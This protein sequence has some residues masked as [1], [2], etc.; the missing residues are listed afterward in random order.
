[1]YDLVDRPV[2]DLDEGSRFLVFAMRSWVRS[3]TERHCPPALLGP[4]FAKWQMTAALPHFHLAMALLNRD[5]LLTFHFGALCCGRVT[6]DEAVLLT[7]FR[8]L[9]SDDLAQSRPTLEL[10]VKAE[11]VPTLHVVMRRVAKGL[12]AAG[13]APSREG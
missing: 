12:M 7:L 1:M 9:R 5:G 13:L 10:L 8:T 6:D 2:Q 11:T 3:M 4:A